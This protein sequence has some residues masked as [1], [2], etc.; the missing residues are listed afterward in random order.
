MQATA[1]RPALQFTQTRQGSAT[2]PT[3]RSPTANAP[4]S[5]PAS[6]IFP[7]PLVAEN[8]GESALQVRAPP[9]IHI[10]GADA[11]RFDANEDLI[12]R[13]SWGRMLLQTQIV[14]TAQD[15]R[16][17]HHQTSCPGLFPGKSGQNCHPF[18]YLDSRSRTLCVICSTI[19]SPPRSPSDQSVQ[20]VVN[21][22]PP[23]VYIPN[24]AAPG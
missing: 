19:P 17:H 6:T 4:T 22:V 2:S 11:A 18:P 10:G 3:T 15:C 13:R 12:R 8:E 5:L 24:T 9:H 14:D 16:S 21:T 23:R 20:P 1:G 7:G